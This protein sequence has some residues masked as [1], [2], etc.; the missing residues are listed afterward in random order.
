VGIKYLL[1]RASILL[2]L[3]D[4]TVMI[5]GL[6]VSSYGFI[7]HTE[8]VDMATALPKDDVIHR[9]S[10]RCKSVKCINGDIDDPLSWVIHGKIDNVEFQ[11]LNAKDIHVTPS[12]HI[13]AKSSNLKIATL[14]DLIQSK[15]VAGGHQDLCDV[16]VLI[17]M[18][19]EFLPVALD[20]A[21]TQQCSDRLNDWLSDKRLLAKYHHAHDDKHDDTSTLSM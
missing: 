2:D 4:E 17:M 21:A 8:D 10:S 6:A 5:G 13:L 20:A 14:S 1:S 16:A 15:I 3:L 11:I 18:H 19:P 12:V 9:L 7:R